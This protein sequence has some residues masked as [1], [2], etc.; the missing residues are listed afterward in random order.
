[1][2]GLLVHVGYG[3]MLCALAARDILW[4]R[5]TLVLAQSVL[6][7]Y[8][9]LIDVPSI[10][11]WNALFVVINTA[12]VIRILHDRRAVAL[13][14]ELQALHARHFYALPP[15]EFL[16]WWGQ[17]RRTTV[18]REVLT[19]QGR[20]PEALFFVLDGTVRVSREGTHVTDLG[21]GHF[22]GEMSLIT[23]RP[24]TADAA[25]LGPVELMRWDAAGLQ[26]VRTGDPQL[27]TR[28]QSAIGQDLVVKI[29]RQGA[30]RV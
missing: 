8:A 28:I 13:P 18:E 19:T 25:A 1:M 7:V 5:G 9:W 15:P 22:V 24:A 14:P 20:F 30:E 10:A 27:W 12:W 4:L 29:G 17:G 23:G 11:A 2:S 3:L 6:S 21:P 26:K 16:R